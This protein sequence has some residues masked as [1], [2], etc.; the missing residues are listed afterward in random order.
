MRKKTII[1]NTGIQAITVRRI[2][3]RGC[4]KRATAE[5][6]GREREQGGR[7]GG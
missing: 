6:G 5:R 3:T 7:G 1:H 2:E 4:G